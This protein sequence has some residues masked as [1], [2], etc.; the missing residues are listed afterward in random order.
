MELFSFVLASGDEHKQM[1]ILFNT[2]LNLTNL[3]AKLS[4]GCTKYKR[5]RFWDMWVKHET[6]N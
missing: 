5:H 4:T 3:L 6:C 1:K 2:N